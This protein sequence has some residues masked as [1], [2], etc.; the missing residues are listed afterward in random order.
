M[1]TTYTTNY[2]LGKQENHA[3]KFDMDVITDNAD[4]IDAALTGLQSGIDGKQAA[5]TTE[6]LAAVNSGITS[7]DVTQIET[8]KNNISF[9]ASQGRKNVLK[10]DSVGGTFNGITYTVNNDGT[11]R[12]N[13]TAID[14][15]YVNL[16]INNSNF[17]AKEYAN[18]QFVLS[19]CPSGGGSGTYSL[20]A[21]KGNYAKF[22][23]GDGVILTPTSESEV[24]IVLRVEKNQTVDIVF[25]PMIRLIGTDSAFEPYALSN[26]ELT[27]EIADIIDSTYGTAHNV[28]LD[29]LTKGGRYLVNGAESSTSNAPF[30][31]WQT[32][33]VYE[34]NLDGYTTLTVQ[35]ATELGAGL[36]RK[37]RR[38]TYSGGD[39]YS[40]WT[41]WT[42]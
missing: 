28:D 40:A 32:V 18:G 8:N 16:R 22:D 14:I 27:A 15:S 21:A 26:A 39:Q 29:T 12:A 13:G 7:T 38:R 33:E 19:G 5:L 34:S 1:A 24:Y 37:F 10:F 25:K 30:A 4:K 3:D 2:N 9:V 23:Y 36:T 41:A 31:N 17:N 11:V 42:S 35:I 6:Q 20:Y